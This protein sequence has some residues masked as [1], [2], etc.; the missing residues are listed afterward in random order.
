[1]KIG[2]LSPKNAVP[3]IPST[4]SGQC[5]PSSLGLDW[6]YP[7]TTADIYTGFPVQ[8]FSIAYRLLHEFHAKKAGKSEWGAKMIG[9]EFFVDRLLGDHPNARF[10]RCLRDGRAVAL[11]LTENDF[12]PT[13]LNGGAHHWVSSM[14]AWDV[15]KTHGPDE[16]FYS[17]RYEDLVTDS[18]E[19]LQNLFKFLKIPWHRD[20]LKYY[21]S[22]FAQTRSNDSGHTNLTRR[23]DSAR[24]IRAFNV[25]STNQ[26]RQI[27]QIA[28]QTMHA[29]PGPW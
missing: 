16:R 22:N 3:T 27:E 9:G 13:T 15:A 24:I 11:S 29:L 17:L 6:E 14:R 25:L 21:D 23:P 28:G 20:C 8:N 19:T 1:M 18:E 10:V 7:P 26:I 12:G 4:P 5:F 2:D